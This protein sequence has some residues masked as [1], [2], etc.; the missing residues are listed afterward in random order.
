VLT[1]FLIMLREGFE[2]AL[3]VAILYA[4]VQRTGRPDLL[5]PLWV[6]V[7][8]AAA[9]SVL[10]GV[11]IHNT[12]DGLVGAARLRAFAAISLAAVI[13]LTW[14][15][16]WMRKHARSIR[17]EL[18]DS[19]HEAISKHDRVGL[20][21][22]FAAFIAVLR[23]GLEASLF[24][25]AT[26]TQE[27]GTGVLTGAFLGLAV[28][29]FLGYLV[30]LGGKRLPLRQF[31]TVTGVILIVFAAGLLS[32]TVMYLQTTGDFFLTW[33]NVYDLTAYPWLTTGT[34][35]GR[36]LGAML[37]WDPRPSIEQ[38]IAYVGYIGIVGFLFL[39]KPR[40]APPSTQPAATAPQSRS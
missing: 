14:M 22:A 34:E 20:A 24:M 11:V 35:V 1:A 9:I 16:F 23:E 12:V 7:G 32:R 5:G 21:V 3:V 13:V 2:A 19:M 28:A 27:N 40:S 31:F 37:G 10:A 39:R 33:N 25:V 17:G 30:V 36:F 8:L 15:I 29:A 38:V 6:G 4:Y 26:A 18:Q